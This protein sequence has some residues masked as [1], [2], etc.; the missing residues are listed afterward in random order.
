MQRIFAVGLIAIALVML[1]YA[2]TGQDGR[3]FDMIS[4]IIIG[5]MAGL[6][7]SNTPIQQKLEA[8]GLKL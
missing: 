6:G 2:S 1:W 5:I 8:A 4:G 7:I 3:V